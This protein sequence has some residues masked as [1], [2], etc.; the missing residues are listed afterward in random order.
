[1][2]SNKENTVVA[3]YASHE[4]AEKAVKELQ[5]SGFDMKKL[6]IIGKDFHTDEH[7]VGFY[8]TGDRM[9]YWGRNGAFWG[10][11]WAIFFGSALF[12]I[13]V[14]GHVIVLGPLVAA[15]ANALGGAAVGG[16]VGILGGA[17]AS[18][19]IP[20]NSVVEYEQ[21]VRAGSF[22]IVAH[23]DPLET[24]RAQKVLQEAG[25]SRVTAHGA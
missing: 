12:F 24:A 15:F 20:E 3:S 16:S 25:A 9:A 14:V 19:G 18:I 1:M 6:S 21:Q 17:L 7:P 23:G 5:R 11:L 2:I 8:N 13:P 10:S 22:L 4:D